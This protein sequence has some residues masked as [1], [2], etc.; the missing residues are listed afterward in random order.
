M[1]IET[2]RDKQGKPIRLAR[3][4]VRAETSKV[5]R[6]R[7]FLCRSAGYFE[8]WRKMVKHGSCDALVF[9]VDGNSA[10]T[11]R[12]LLYHFKRILESAGIRNLVT[13][14][15]VPYSLRHYMI[16]QRIM[17]GVDF[18]AIADMCGTSITQIERVYYHLNDTIRL[19]NA[20]ANY[21]LDS[22]GTIRVV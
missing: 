3:I 10:I 21:R 18:R 9:S 14:S 5:R 16:T 12:A 6:S 13:R 11:K 20:V 15:I 2:H 7:I 8:A 1:E 19:T 4:H 17:S 22:D